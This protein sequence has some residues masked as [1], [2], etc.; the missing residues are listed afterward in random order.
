MGFLLRHLNRARSG[1]TCFGRP[2][3]WVLKDWCLS[4]VIDRIRRGGD[5]IGCDVY[6][7]NADMRRHMLRP[8]VPDY[9][10]AQTSTISLRPGTPRPRPSSRWMGLTQLLPK[11]VQKSYQQCSGTQTKIPAYAL[12]GTA[13]H[14]HLKVI[15]SGNPSQRSDGDC[16]YHNVL[17]SN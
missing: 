7:P 17:Q 16:L 5:R 2:A 10:P 8:R 3:T 13:Q 14:A 4:G 9:D 15:C 1:R 6:C 12:T 11:A